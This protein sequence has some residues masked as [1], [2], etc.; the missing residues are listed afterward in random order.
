[1]KKLCKILYKFEAKKIYRDAVKKLLSQQALYISIKGGID[2][3]SP[4]NSEAIKVYEDFRKSL[5]DTIISDYEYDSYDPT[6]PYKINTYFCLKG[7]IKDYVNI[8]ALLEEFK[9]NGVNL[10][11]DEKLSILEQCDCDIC[12]YGTPLAPKYKGL[13][14]DTTEI[15]IKSILFGVPVAEARKKFGS[16]FDFWI[17]S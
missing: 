10:C 2:L 14:P 11:E 1:M 8:D 4:N 13:P 6:Q 16:N 17:I 9:K 12:N 5:P 15:V 3:C 7:K